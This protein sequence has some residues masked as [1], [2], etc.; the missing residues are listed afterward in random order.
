MLLLLAWMLSMEIP[1]VSME[2]PNRQPQ[3]AVS[4]AGIAL[5]FGS[6]RTILY[7]GSQEGETFAKPA[8]VAEV[9]G[10]MLG[11]HRGPRVV[12]SGKVLAVSAVS[13]AD[14]N[15]LLWRSTDG[16][17]RW[18]AARVINDVEGA[19]REGLHAMAADDEGNIAVVW[20]DLR[21]KGT[22]LYGAV[23]KDAGATWSRN[24]LVYESPGGTI[25][26]CCHPTLLSLGK[27][28]FGVMFRNA[29]DGKRDMYVTRIRGSEVI[30]AAHKA[31]KG[32]WELNACP[33]DGGGLALSG[34]Q[35]MTAWRRGDEVFMAAEDKQESRI[36]KGK[37][38]AIASDGKRVFMVWTGDGGIESWVEGKADVLGEGASPAITA[39]PEGGALAAWE[40]NGTIVLR[41]LK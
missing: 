19:A 36:G 15:L 6:G 9:P 29:V 12:F 17:A 35:L 26:Q 11:R 33:M 7:T 38:V 8:P 2:A 20:L 37:D 24:F 41:R 34:K 27:G 30:S 32:S 40:Q 5:V 28:G 3:L 16:G 21:A 18:S 39:L 22:R 13:N 10:L 14:G 25:C 4:Q 31:G 23:S 1:P